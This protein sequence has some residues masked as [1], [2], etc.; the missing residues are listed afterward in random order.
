MVIILTTTRPTLI[1]NENPKRKRIMIQMQP[2]DVDGNNT[3]L[4]HIGTG[5]QPVATVG[6]P[7]QGEI[8]LQ[9]GAIVE[10]AAGEKISERFKRTIWATSSL[11]NQTLTVEEETNN[12]TL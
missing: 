4:I 2:F 11:A 10:P 12:E 1:L 8:L 5:F 6:H 9:A 3:G 7:S